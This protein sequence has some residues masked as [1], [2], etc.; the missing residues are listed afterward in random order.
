MPTI[1]GAALQPAFQSAVL[2]ACVE[3]WRRQTRSPADFAWV[4]VEAL[5]RAVPGGETTRAGRAAAIGAAMTALMSGRRGSDGAPPLEVVGV[6]RTGGA[7]MAEVAWRLR[8][9]GG[10]IN[11]G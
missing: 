7:Q 10:H 4:T 9:N 8:P 1:D 6:R 11:G 2:D 5:A 3:E